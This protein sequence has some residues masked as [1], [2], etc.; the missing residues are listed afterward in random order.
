MFGIQHKV[1]DTARKAG[2]VTASAALTI[3]G[4]GFFTAA[5]WIY[6]S[7]QQTP[8]FA[9]V[10]IGAV[11]FGA[12]AITLAIGLSRP[13]HNEAKEQDA[14]NGLSPMQLVLISFLQGLDQGRNTKRPH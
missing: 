12:A 4:A 3:V 8:L 9:A 6:L 11:Y 5:A 2:L 7:A 1:A 13:Q 10:V 14:L